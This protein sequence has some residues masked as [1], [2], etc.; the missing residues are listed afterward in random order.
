MVMF[1]GFYDPKETEEE[2]QSAFDSWVESGSTE[3]FGVLLQ[4]DRPIPH[5]ARNLIAEILLGYGRRKILQSL[6][7]EQMLE[8]DLILFR[9]YLVLIKHYRDQ[10]HIKPKIRGGESPR[11][12]AIYHLASSY[13]L[14]ED[15]VAKILKKFKGHQS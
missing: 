8:R 5:W 7:E 6:E 13:G 15:H 4:G 12:Q 2:W 11:E 10:R 1:E 3:E 9:G 14:S